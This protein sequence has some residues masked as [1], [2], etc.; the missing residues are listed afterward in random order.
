[1]LFSCKGGGEIFSAPI[2]QD[3]NRPR[4]QSLAIA[5]SLR[6]FPRSVKKRMKRVDRR[7]GCI[8]N[9]KLIAQ[10]VLGQTS[11]L[12]M[13]STTLLWRYYRASETQ[14]VPSPSWR[15]ASWHFSSF[16]TTGPPAPPLFQF[17]RKNGEVERWRGRRARER[18]TKRDFVDII[19]RAASVCRMRASVY[20]RTYVHN[21]ATWNQ[22]SMEWPFHVRSQ[23]NFQQKEKH[24]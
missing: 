22:K 18:K 15:S 1:M 3:K 13:F 4:S 16:T 6:P 24:R 2:N 9:S 10:S 20:L 7:H 23:L 8:E 14:F 17:Q 5:S 12:Q 21:I 19:I 11:F